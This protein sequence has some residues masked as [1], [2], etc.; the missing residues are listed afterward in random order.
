MRKGV[1]NAVLGLGGLVIALSLAAGVLLYRHLQVADHDY[2]VSVARP[3]YAGTGPRICIDEAHHNF[4]T[5]R[6]RYEPFARLA[7][8]DGFRVSAITD[9]FTAS[10]LAACDILVVAN[11]LGASLPVLPSA[12]NAAFTDAEGDAAYAWV[13]SGGALLLVADHEPAGAAAAKFARRF[14]VDM[15]TGRTFDDPHSDWTSG[16]SAWLVFGR[17]TGARILDHPITRG[18]DS[19]ERIERVVTFTGQSLRGPDGSV[20]FL[21]LASSARD[22]LPDKREVSAAGRAQAVAFTLSK[23]RVVV[24]GEAAVLSAQVTGGGSRR[25]G[26]NWPNTDDRQLALNILHWLSGMLPAGLSLP[27][28]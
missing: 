27:S 6:D 11:A 9:V 8:N 25:F 13:T 19:S 1:R 15:S 17:D 26:M 18:R 5:A 28:Q 12:S 7:A 20:G 21:A 22:R 24:L 4:A 23:G 10:S 16:S 14:G 2:D 3:A